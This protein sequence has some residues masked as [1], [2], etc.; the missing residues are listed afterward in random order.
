MESAIVTDP[1][2]SPAPRSPTG[3]RSSP[4]GEPGSWVTSNEPESPA[5]MTPAFEP[6]MFCPVKRAVRL[7]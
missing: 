4:S 7:S 2:S 6:T 5:A 3:A 1:S